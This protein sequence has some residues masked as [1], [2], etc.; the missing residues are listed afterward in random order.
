MD[1]TFAEFKQ[2][3]YSRVKDFS[4]FDSGEFNLLK[5]VLDGLKVDYASKGKIRVF[6]FS[7]PFV[8]N[9]YFFANRLRSTFLGGKTSVRKNWIEAVRKISSRKYITIDPGGRTLKTEEGIISFYFGNILKTLGKENVISIVEG[10]KPNLPENDL[11]IAEYNALLAS[12]CGN[13]KEEDK[14]QLK[15]LRNTYKKIEDSG[16]FSESEKLNIRIAIQQFFIQNLFWRNVLRY[17]NPEKVLLWPHYH[18]EGCIAAFREKKIHVIELQHG[19]IAAEDIFYVLPEQVR[20]VEKKALFADEI[21]VYGQFWKDQLLKGAGYEEK[22]IK[23]SGFYPVSIVPPEKTVADFKTIFPGKKNILVTTQTFMHEYFCDY[24]KFLSADISARALPYGIIVKLH[25]AE[26][27]DK[28]SSLNG[29]ENVKIVNENLD[30]LFRAVDLHISSYSTTLFDALRFDVP[31]Y[32]IWVEQYGDYIALFR[33]EGISR[34]ING[35]K[36]PLDF[37]LADKQHKAGNYYYE[38]FD[39]STLKQLLS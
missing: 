35:K 19:L 18:R 1:K 24:I 39:P 26:S 17:I 37:P 12:A 5:V 36:N 38:K 13:L 4:L 25:P 33:D 32:S 30:V 7:Y 23:I 6:I 2:D 34:V 27:P 21:W 28:Y 31:N 15:L 8:I 29:L 11:H 16:I 10:R 9:L 20:S 22:Q 3:F 14:E